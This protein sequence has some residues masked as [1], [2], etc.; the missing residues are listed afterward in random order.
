MNT[1][2][3]RAKGF[4]LVELIIT[5]VVMS[6]LLT[7]AVPAM[8]RFLDS[9]RLISAAEQAYSHLQLARMEAIAR[10]R[11][12]SANFSADGSTTW[13]YGVSHNA[14][15]DLTTTTV[16]DANACVVVTDDGDASV[17]PGDGSVDTG[18]L[19]LMRFSDADHDRVSMGT[20]NF[21]SGNTQ[22]QFDPVRGTATAGDISFT[23]EGGKQ[24]KVKVGTLGQIRVCSPDGSMPRYSTASC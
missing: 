6:L 20:A 1:Y 3:R 24:L 7:Q 21:A 2:L 11:T 18:D 22:I 4:T 16:T 5:L 23:S 12:M 13:Q 19:V 10:S 15:C 14:T 9:K 8:G 17:D